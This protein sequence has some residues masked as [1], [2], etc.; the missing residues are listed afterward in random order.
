MRS[1]IL[2]AVLAVAAPGMGPQL[3]RPVPPE[4]ISALDLTVMPDGAG[5]PLGRGSVA[6]GAVVYAERC[7]ACHGARGEGGVEMTPVPPRLTGGVGSLAGPAPVRTVASYWPHAPGLFDYVRRS[8]PP[9]EPGAL[10]DDDTYAVVAYLLSIDGI[11]G[12]KAT[13]DARTLPRVRMPN[14]HGFVRAKE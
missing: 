14:A 13:V 4:T 3:G 9:E 12:P 11:V 1:L 8:M 2:A 6:R 7:E 10:S 5:L